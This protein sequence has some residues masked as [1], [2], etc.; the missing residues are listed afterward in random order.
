MIEDPVMVS[1]SWQRSLLWAVAR[2]QIM[3]KIT[4]RASSWAWR[5]LDGPIVPC[6]RC[7]P[8]AWIEFDKTRH[9]EYS[10]DLEDKALPFGAVNGGLLKIR[11]RTR[12]LDSIP[13]RY[14]YFATVREDVD[15]TIESEGIFINLSPDTTEAE[16][17]MI[18]AIRG[19]CR[20]LLLEL[21][22]FSENKR[23]PIGLIIAPEENGRETGR[24]VRIGMFEI[25]QR[26]RSETEVETP[27]RRA[28]F[29]RLPLRDISI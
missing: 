26:D 19:T 18:Q 14:I 10:V 4:G 23:S 7:R 3:R 6:E 22:P 8:Q 20:A 21:I 17:T 28:L 12:S 24:Y 2:T 5:A 25:P 27:Y 16:A 29:D 15:R 13:E 9:L 11:A 1:Y